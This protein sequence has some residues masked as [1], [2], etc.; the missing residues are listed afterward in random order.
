MNDIKFSLFEGRTFLIV[1]QQQLKVLSSAVLGGGLRR[2]RFIINH[3]VDRNYYGKLTPAKYLSHMARKMNLGSDTVGLMTA[4]DVKRTVM[5]FGTRDDVAVAALSTVGVGNACSAGA[6]NA[7]FKGEDR[8]GT[9]N[10][11]VLIDGD[12]TDAA[13]VNAVITA[14]EAKSMAMMHADIRLPDGTVATGTTTDAIVIACTAKGRLHHYSGMATDLGFLVG[15]AVYKAVAEGIS[16]SCA[17]E[18][19]Y[20]CVK[21]N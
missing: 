1:S 14:T 12:L 15:R 2:V 11:V 4:V 10:I 8:P 6:K 13:M 7:F 20:G 21:L 3:T 18:G 17:Y 16:N 19:S 9:I 5:S